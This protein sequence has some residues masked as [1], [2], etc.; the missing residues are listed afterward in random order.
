[1]TNHQRN[2]HRSTLFVVLLLLAI[3]LQVPDVWWRD[4]A[5]PTGNARTG[6]LSS[7]GSAL[8]ET[9]RERRESRIRDRHRDVARPHRRRI[10]TSPQGSIVRN[11]QEMAG[12]DLPIAEIAEESEFRLASWP[13]GG[14]PIDSTIS[15]VDRSVDH[16]T[17]AYPPIRTAKFPTRGNEPSSRPSLG[18]TTESESNSESKSSIE[19]APRPLDPIDVPNQNLL[20]P[21]LVGGESSDTS[22]ESDQSAKWELS[23]SLIQQFEEL[24]R[25]HCNQ[26]VSGWIDTCV[27]KLKTLAGESIE[28]PKSV[29]VLAELAKLA[30]VPE[31]TDPATGSLSDDAHVRRAAYSLERRCLVWN[32]VRNVQLAGESTVMKSDS[33]RIVTAVDAVDERFA[34]EDSNS[35][36]WQTYLRLDEIREASTLS[37][38]DASQRRA[39]AQDV[40]NRFESNSLTT[41]Q[42]RFL[43]QAQF[44]TLQSSLQP[45][46]FEPFDARLFLLS[47]ENFESTPTATAAATLVDQVRNLNRYGSNP[48]EQSPHR[49]LAQIVETHYRNANVRVA[50]S[51]ELLNQL[52]PVVG[53]MQEA[54]SENFL[55][56]TVSGQNQTWT[57]LAVELVPDSNRINVRLNASGTTESQT[58]SK[59]GPVRLFSRGN[60]WF[61]A[62]VPIFMNKR[63]VGA[64]SADANASGGDRLVDVRTDYDRVPILGWLIR[65]LAIGEHQDNRNLVHRHVKNKMTKAAK[66]RL[67][68]VVQDRIDATQSVMKKKL[69]EPLQAVDVN[70]KALEMKTDQHRVTMRCRLA[71]AQQ[72]SAHT[73]RPRAVAGSVFSMQMHQSAI[74]NVV[75]QMEL[76]GQRIQLEELIDR[77]RD[78]LGVARQDIHSDIPEGVQIRLADGQ[79]LSVEFDDDRVLVAIRISE[80]VTR[81][82]TYRNF[83]VRARYTADVDDFNLNLTR[84]GGIEL[85]SEQIGFRDQFALRGIFT[86]V[87]ANDHR[88]KILRGRFEEDPRLA[89]L[90]WLVWWQKWI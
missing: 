3:A 12:D 33:A 7:V 23:Q 18:P 43:Q 16:P 35:R 19:P 4:F 14:S 2:S 38:G 86:K 81:R 79:P 25:L 44:V 57:K 69:I 55:G 27:T 49:D 46:A 58:V 36:D 63:G 78:R 47:V 32:A 17:S 13:I 34:S 52:L 20:E 66:Q 60:G 45:W 26:R 71:G 48:D 70:V 56:A 62:G 88:L 5:S 84:E 74:N 37:N 31:A 89:R 59:K 65:Q 82:R 75:Q 77:L 8:K 87:M 61:R 64:S 30:V 50:V 73:A 11:T 6:T 51:G 85:I 10:Q 53:P 42:T 40:L 68:K 24:R 1:M 41:D 28:S 29:E 67:D 80:L 9:P 76:S 90:I 72:L 54:V 39:I 22:T 21:Q 83:V 15:V